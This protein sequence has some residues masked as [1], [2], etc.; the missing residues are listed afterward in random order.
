M[1]EHP[2]GKGHRHRRHDKHGNEVGG[3]HGKR[4]P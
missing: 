2:C 3:D 1:S 4:S